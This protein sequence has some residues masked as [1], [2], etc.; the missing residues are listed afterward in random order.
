MLDGQPYRT[1]IAHNFELGSYQ[2]Q[3]HFVNAVPNTMLAGL[4]YKIDML[5]GYRNVRHA[6]QLAQ[7]KP[8]SHRLAVILDS[9]QNAVA[10]S[11][12]AL[13]FLI[14]VLYHA[15]SLDGVHSFF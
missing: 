11:M 7:V 10:H 9:I 3:R 12:L 4:I 6:V 5:V 1:H 14:F 15:V 2:M 13:G 8:L